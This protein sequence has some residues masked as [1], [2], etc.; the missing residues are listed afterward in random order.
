MR[1]IITG[2]FYTICILLN[3]NL[4]SNDNYLLP[5]PKSIKYN[6]DKPFILDCVQLIDSTHN[7]LLLKF[8]EDNCQNSNN[9]IP[10][11]IMTQRVS[12][13]ENS[14]DYKLYGYDNEAYK[15]SI[16][17]NSILIEYIDDIGITRATQ[18]LTQLIDIDKIG[19]KALPSSTIIDWPSFKLR[20]FMH[21]VGRSFIPIDEIKRHIDILSHFKINTFHWHLTENQAWRFEVKRYPQLTDSNTMTRHKNGF[22]TQE[23]CKALEQYAWE[24]GV[25]VI[26]EIDMPGHSA[27]FKRAMGHSM[28][29]DEGIEEL[30]FILEEV[31]ATF[32]RAPYIHI[33]GD[34]EPITY[35]NFFNIIT[36][37]VHSLSK[38]VIVWNPI[39][40]Y[41]INGEDDGFDMTQMWSTAG[42]KITGIPNIDCRYNYINHFDVFADV[43]G[44][45]K[46]NIYYS[47]VGSEEIAGTITAVW[48]DRKLPTSEDIIMQNSF[49]ANV[50][51]SAERAWIGGGNA[52]IEDGGTTLPCFGEEYDE[53]ADWERRFLH[54]KNTILSSEPIPY[55]KQSNI[56][57][58]ITDAFPNENNAE[59]SFPPEKYINSK[60][61]EQF[62]YKGITYNSNIA[63]GGGIYLRHTWGNTVPAF[64]QDPQIGHTAYAWTYIYSPKKQSVGAIIEFQNYSR[65]EKDEAPDNN[66]WDKKGSRIWLN[67]KEILPYNWDNH[68]VKIDNEV[69][70]KNENFPAREPIL[71]ELKRGWNKVFIKL[72]YVKT[73]GIRLNKWMFTF[74]LTD[75]CGKNAVDGL[76]YSPDKKK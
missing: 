61:P 67:D 37:K 11:T 36:D 70:L 13:I 22:Y 57:W 58:R 41:E 43:V 46:S 34:E 51:A 5:K 71:V 26:P 18:T 6:N 33:G 69:D 59:M 50:I 66:C 17:D 8:V 64:F 56:K 47:E 63:C 2:L 62:E 9:G 40:G 76:I 4:L 48:N 16:T 49:Y 24:R 35:P 27:A 28:Q 42:K 20:G 12:E 39:Y 21:D 7:K 55:V 45:Y 73:E 53:F 30:L 29:T 54:Y 31:A 65:S 10:K 72:P 3:V 19:R 23:E 32:P 44:I 14:Y 15:I 74:V 68:N 75:K 60:S 1:N 38:K 52:Y 25:I